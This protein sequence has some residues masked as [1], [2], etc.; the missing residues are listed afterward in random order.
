[1]PAHA[2]DRVRADRY[3]VGSRV[4]GC[5][6]LPRSADR[7]SRCR[8]GEL[9]S[10]YVSPELGQISA[11]LTA[12]GAIERI[13]EGFIQHSQVPDLHRSAGRCLLDGAYPPG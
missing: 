8:H 2:A 12:G 9:G 11:H 10:S 7:G 1:M 6:R 3:E 13:A 5:V 4:H